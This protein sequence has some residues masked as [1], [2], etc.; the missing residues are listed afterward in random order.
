MAKPTPIYDKKTKKLKGSIGVGK[1]NVPTTPPKTVHLRANAAA[2]SMQPT[3]QY[4]PKLIEIPTHYIYQTKNDKIKQ[5]TPDAD[6]KI[7]F[8]IKPGTGIGR[9]N[10]AAYEKRE[11]Q[12]SHLEEL[13]TDPRELIKLLESQTTQLSDPTISFKKRE[14]IQGYPK[15]YL[16]IEGWNP[17]TTAEIE[18]MKAAETLA[19]DTKRKEREAKK[20][21]KQADKIRKS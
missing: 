6:S 20:L 21:E 13:P 10:P 15:T 14:L 12:Y 4:E 8:R 5:L 16:R 18:G 19:K 3:T 7:I 2:I 17:A 11:I 9:G 1:T